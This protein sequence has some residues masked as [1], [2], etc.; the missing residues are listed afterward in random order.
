MEMEPRHLQS[1]QQWVQDEQL[2][3][4]SAHGQ[5]IFFFSTTSR[6][7]L[8]PNSQGVPWT[9]SLGAKQLGHEDD[10]SSLHSAELKKGGVKPP[11]HNSPSCYDV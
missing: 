10:L 4:N 6:L 1:I 7:A 5:E 3:F 8:E 2:G 9:L 11:L